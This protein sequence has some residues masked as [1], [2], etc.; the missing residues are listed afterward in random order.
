MTTVV[1]GNG[2]YVCVHWVIEKGRENVIITSVWATG[3]L[4]MFLSSR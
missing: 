1:M 3:G 4:R 2:V